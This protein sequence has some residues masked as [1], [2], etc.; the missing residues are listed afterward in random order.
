M[1]PLKQIPATAIASKKAGSRQQQHP[2]VP[3]AKPAG[4]DFLRSQPENMAR[5]S[6]VSRRQEQQNSLVQHG[7]LCRRRG[8]A[9]N[10][11]IS[12][13]NT[14]REASRSW[15]SRESRPM[16]PKSSRAGREVTLHIMSRLFVRRRLRGRVFE[17][18]ILPNGEHHAGLASPASYCKDDRDCT[19][20]PLRNA[21]VDLHHANCAGRLA[22]E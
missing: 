10:A 6:I 22:A 14:A 16:S 20:E 2:A 12:L 3:A 1:L 17:E 8:S 18:E 5:A 11:G 21:G 4:K 9:N 7:R 15:T 13:V 19:I